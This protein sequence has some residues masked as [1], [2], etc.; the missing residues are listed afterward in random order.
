MFVSFNSKMIG[1]TN[2]AGNAYPSGVHE[3]TPEGF[4][5]LH[6][7]FPV[8]CIVDHCFLLFL[9]RLVIVLSVWGK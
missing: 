9:F 5:L 1:A 3:F 6:L 8:Q 2:G 4:V 7:W